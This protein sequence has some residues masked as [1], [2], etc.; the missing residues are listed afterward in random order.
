MQKKKG[1]INF[2]KVK[3]GEVTQVDERGNNPTGDSSQK[4]GVGMMQT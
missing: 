2:I 4:G 3:E 1:E